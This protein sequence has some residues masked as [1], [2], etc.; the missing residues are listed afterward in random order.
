[1]DVVILAGGK[2]RRFGAAKQF[3]PVAPDGATLLEV[4]VRDAQRAGCGR[5]VI[6][7]APGSEEEVLGLFAARPVPGL[8][9]VAVPQRPD[10]L[11]D[12]VPVRD[13]PWGT[14]HALWAVRSVVAG[15]FLLFNADDH[16]GPYAPAALTVAFGNAGSSADFVMLG[17]PLG[18]TL[19]DSGT[20]SRAV[21]TVDDEGWLTGMQEYTAVDGRG[22]VASGPGEGIML[23]LG[24]S[25]SMNAWVFTPAVFP[26]I[27][28]AL[29]EFAATADLAQEECFLPGV[30]DR[31][32]REGRARVEVVAAP[33]RWCGMTW[34]EDR[35]RVARRLADFSALDEVRVAF[36]LASAPRGA[37]P[38]G[39]GLVHATW[40]LED[41][42]G[43]HLLQR[44][45]DTVFNDPVLVA[46]NAATASARI[47]D[48][49]RRSGDVD[50]R[51]RLTY[52]L[53]GSGRP[54]HRDFRGGVW[55]C[56]IGIPGA[57][58]ADPARPGEIRGAARLLGR[59]PGLVAR[60]RGPELRETIP[61]FH[62]TPAR[63]AALEGAAEADVQGRLKGCRGEWERLLG[64]GHL[65][66]RLGGSGLPLRPVHNDAKPDNV[67]V[68]TGTGEALCVID[69]D[70][71]MPGI[72]PLD[73][74][75]LVRAAVTGRPEDE[76]DPARI[77]LREVVFRELAGGYLAGAWEWITPAERAALVDGALVITYEQA[78]RF[79]TDH[80]SGDVYYRITESGHNLRRARAQLRLLDLLLDGEQ[81]LRA[82][83]A[84]C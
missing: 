12:A 3:V 37:A 81:D 38:F 55:R 62:D 59:F 58:P 50:P 48:A 44:L 67:L 14:A 19:S 27:E 5:A 33:D 32:V 36:G 28:E 84:G 63:L 78:L 17:F 79:L 45:N 16:Y 21:C 66:G 41:S 57:R 77:A 39:T 7:V 51:H 75:D 83:V 73:F 29:R 8:D 23:P 71:V 11:P 74:G 68:D 69:L 47:D 46:G 65:A 56:L 13:R 26:L 20:V 70:T 52:R 60:G 31:A 43:F 54:W 53:D 22:R 42:A 80:L 18:E 1:M 40:K 2:G 72:A 10:D 15:P 34:P 49:L 61:G 25:V 6:V 76:P 9:V 4:T 35:D 24:A 64:L 82:I 30:I